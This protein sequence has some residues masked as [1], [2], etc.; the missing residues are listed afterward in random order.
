M[1]LDRRVCLGETRRRVD[2]DAKEALLEHPRRG[3]LA[4]VAWTLAKTAADER[5]KRFGDGLDELLREHGLGEGEGD[6]AGVD[7]FAALA[8]KTSAGESALTHDEARVVSRLAALGLASE[9]GTLQ[10]RATP[11]AAAL[12]WLGAN[13]PL[14]VLA[15]VEGA[16]GADV[17]ALGAALADLVRARDACLAKSGRGEALYAIAALRKLGSAGAA[18]LAGLVEDLSDPT[19]RGVGAELTL[20]RVRSD[21]EGSAASGDAAPNGPASR[22]SRSGGRQ[23][24]ARVAGVWVPAPL[25]AARLLLEALTG[26]LLVRAV[27][28]AFPGIFMRRRNEGELVVAA[29]GIAIV[30]KLELFGRTVR[31]R[32]VL[33]P[34]DNLARAVREVSYPRLALYVGMIALGLGTYVGSTLMLDGGRV[35]SPSLIAVGA[36]V[37]AVGLALDLLL[38]RLGQRHGKHRIV[39]VPRKGKS[40]A[41]VARDA[42][43]ADQVMRELVAKA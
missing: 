11:I 14:D 19:L 33:I 23:P 21:G 7:V 2:G 36:A 37:F 25:G 3:E 15:H 28:R 22:G 31:S 27:L 32:E 18:V 17:E 42:R 41:L 39:L 16:D 12:V 20:A 4:N 26:L 6:V 43:A 29:S 13:T 30:E 9:D 5:R 8:R 24:S 35:G 10:D 34:F 38:A 40:Y 1:T